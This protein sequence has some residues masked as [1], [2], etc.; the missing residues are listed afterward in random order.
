VI[1]VRS[2]SIINAR[3]VD[4]RLYPSRRDGLHRCSSLPDRKSIET[5]VIE[6]VFACAVVG[7]PLFL[8][9]PKNLTPV[10]EKNKK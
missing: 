5:A 8:R 4:R 1:Y 7:V 9:V 2:V 6:T 3:T 10:K